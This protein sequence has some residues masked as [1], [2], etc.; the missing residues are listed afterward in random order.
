MESKT[1]QEHA[2]IAAD[3]VILKNPITSE[4]V[5]TFEVDTKET[6]K[7]LEELQEK[8]KQGF[9]KIPDF[10]NWRVFNFNGTTV[11]LLFNIDNN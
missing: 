10:N 7:Y 1:I 5:V 4:G 6:I 11:P 8:A 2:Q 9:I 3:K